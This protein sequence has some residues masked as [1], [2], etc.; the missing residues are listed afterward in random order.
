MSSS[1]SG[2]SLSGANNCD[3][4]KLLST[5][6]V[7]HAALANVL[8]S[9][10]VCS[11]RSAKRKLQQIKRSTDEFVV[12]LG[13]PGLDIRMVD[14]VQLMKKLAEQSGAFGQLLAKAALDHKE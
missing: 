9:L 12:P 11:S 4:Q 1:S 6:K 5:P 14:V 3:W 8:S 7:S 2:F 13:L 10:G